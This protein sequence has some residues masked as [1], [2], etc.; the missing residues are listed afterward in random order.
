MKT[1]LILKIS[2]LVFAFVAVLYG[3]KALQSP[4]TQRHASDPNSVIGLLVG[5]EY[6]LLS[7]CPEKTVKLEL[8]SENSEVLKTF[9]SAQDLSAACELMVGSF[10]QEQNYEPKYRPLL[11]AVSESGETKILEKD[12]G[13]EI[14]RVQG[15]PFSSPGLVKVLKRFEAP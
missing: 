6:R 1:G 10:S 7:W 11:K 9:S 14:F 12:V 8:L 15:M 5:G 4:Q 13:K 3:I 2:M